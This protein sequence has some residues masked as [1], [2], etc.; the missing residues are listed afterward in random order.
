MDLKYKRLA[1]SLVLCWLALIGLWLMLSG[2]LE[3]ARAA[4]GASLAA[5]ATRFVASDGDDA[6]DC[7]S[8]E[9]RCRTVQRAID[10][11]EPLDEIWVAT[12]TYTGTAGTVADIEKSVT[13]LGGWDAGFT[14]RDSTLNPT[15]LDAQGAGRVMYIHGHISPTIDGF[16]ITGGNASNTSDYAAYGGGIHSRDANPIITH[17]VITG[18]VASDSPDAHGRGGGLYLRNSS[19]SA[20]VSGNHILSNTASTGYYGYGGGLF[21]DRSE[22]SVS[23]NIVRDNLASSADQGSGGGVYLTISPATLRGNIISGNVASIAESGQGGGLVLYHSPATL[24]GNYIINNV[25][26]GGGGGLLLERC[27]PFTLTNNIIAHN[28]ASDVG[29]GGG[30]KFWGWSGGPARGVLAHNTIAQNDRGSGGEGIFTSGVVTLTLGNN[31]IVSHTYGIYAAGGSSV[32]ASHTLFFSHTVANIHQGGGAVVSSTNEITGSDP[33]FVNPA[34]EDYD[35][36]L[37]SSAIN[38]GQAV[39]WL[40]TDIRGALRHFGPAPDLGAFEVAA[41]LSIH[42]TGLATA[43]PGQA[44]TYTLRVT[45]SGTYTASAVVISDALPAGAHYVGG[46][47]LMP[48]DV[49]SWS[50]GSLAGGAHA[51]VQFVVTATETV[52]NSVYGVTCAEGVSAQGTRDVATVIG[53]PEL[54]IRKTGPATA[55]PGQPITYTLTITNNGTAPATGLVISDVLPLG[56]EYVGGG[57]L[58][59][60]DVVRWTIASLAGGGAQAQVQFA[61]TAIETI[62]NEVYGV[63]CAEGVSALGSEPVVTAVQQWTIYLPAVLKSYSGP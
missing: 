14:V 37:D 51:Q 35:L 10:V 61:V 36:M 18:N 25:S 16:T 46:G 52:V 23:H 15:T 7:S 2:G 29:G 30:I 58:L 26:P 32:T 53:S 41:I 43:D 60:G 31:I 59:L 17:N 6:N 9:Q 34:G 22:A 47:T 42:K 40:H 4:P 38:A 54:L 12:G 56:A 19:A 39:P 13:L 24:D 49:V 1:F 20:V 55:I 11:A 21:L 27:I 44:I 57:T 8:I 28:E 48:G 3:M 45:N 5:P 33:S 50:V 63:T 62:T